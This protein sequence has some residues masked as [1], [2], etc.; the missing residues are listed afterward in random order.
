MCHKYRT[1]YILFIQSCILL[2]FFA[3]ASH[4]WLITLAR[5]IRF[6]RVSTKKN[7][8]TKYGRIVIDPSHIVA[9]ISERRQAHNLSLRA[10]AEKADVSLGTVV[11][12]E[13]GRHNVQL[14][15]LL[16]VLAVLDLVPQDLW[17][18]LPTDVTKESLQHQL[19]DVASAPVPSEFLA[20][21]SR[22]FKKNGL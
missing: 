4:L 14:E 15:K 11:A 3:T 6:N 1:Y 16:Q 21:L 8:G 19:E 2:H 5:R 7:S 17:Q 13:Q 20:R 12:L 10:L 22:V 18:T 9:V